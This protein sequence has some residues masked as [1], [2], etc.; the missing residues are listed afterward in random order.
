[1][2][3]HKQ[4]SPNV[5]NADGA[6]RID[7][8]ASRFKASMEVTNIDFLYLYNAKYQLSNQLYAKDA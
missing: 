4:L 3:S 8:A 6:T 5:T 1:M 2:W 7:S